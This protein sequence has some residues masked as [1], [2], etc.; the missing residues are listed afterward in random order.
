MQVHK[1]QLRD[2]PAAGS[3]MAPLAWDQRMIYNRDGQLLFRR[4]PRIKNFRSSGLHINLW[5]LKFVETCICSIISK[6]LLLHSSILLYMHK[7]VI[8]YCLAGNYI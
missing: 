3:E 5:P 2:Q 6:H 7:V 1:A 8:S 4:W